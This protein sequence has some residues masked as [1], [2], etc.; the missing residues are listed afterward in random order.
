MIGGPLR[1]SITGTCHDCG[2]NIPA[3]SDPVRRTMNGRLYFVRQCPACD[4]RRVFIVS[5]SRQPMEG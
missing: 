1:V 3:G 4:H 2:T 5:P